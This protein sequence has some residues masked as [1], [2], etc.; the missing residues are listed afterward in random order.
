MFDNGLNHTKE[1]CTMGNQILVACRDAWY[2]RLDDFFV[3]RLLHC[4][5]RS[6]HFLPDIV[7]LTISQV[8]Q[9]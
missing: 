7:S 5:E 8:I 4:A 9:N 1:N 2:D 3:C 6:Q